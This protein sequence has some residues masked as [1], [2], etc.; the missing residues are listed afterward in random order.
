MSKLTLEQAV[1]QADLLVDRP[2]IDKA[3]AG[4]ADAIARD[5]KGEVPVFLSIMNGALPFAGQLA[6]ELGARGQD[7][8]FDYMQASRYHGESGGELVWKHRP[9][10]SLF[11]RRVLLVDDI[12]DEGFTLQGVRDWCLEQ[13][14][15]DVRIAVLT[16]K[17]HDRCLDGVKADYAGIELPDRFVFGFGMDVSESLRSLP[18]IYAMKQ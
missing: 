14:A 6:L 7:A 8:Q 18:A 17:K 12:L 1:A 13:G 5:Y 9:V 16:V 15:T 4:I 11:G 3:I 2:A 10:S